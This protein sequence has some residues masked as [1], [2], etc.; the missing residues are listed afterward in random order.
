MLKLTTPTTRIQ[1]PEFKPSGDLALVQAVADALAAA[2]G[3]SRDLVVHD[4]GELAVEVTPMS[5][6]D[7]HRVDAW[8][9][10]ANEGDLEEG[11]EV[12]LRVDLLGHQIE[13]YF[14]A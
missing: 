3:Q 5:R 9:T 1:R 2:V 7:R 13:V 8:V 10:G 4:D 14:R 6:M 11:D 12:C